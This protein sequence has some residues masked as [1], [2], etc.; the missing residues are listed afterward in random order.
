MGSLSESNVISIKIL[1][2]WNRKD[3]FMKNRIIQRT[4][5]LIILLSA[6]RCLLAGCGKPT[7]FEGYRVS[8]EKGFWMEYAILDREETV[9]MSLVEGE[10]L[11]VSMTH[12]IGDVD[13]RVGRMGK[14]PIYQ[15][16]GQTN[17]DFVLIIP[18]TG[19]YR[20]S[21]TGHRAKG[22]VSFVRTA[23]EED[24]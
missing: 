3:R 8:D 19:T 6:V 2:I 4:F 9:D 24:Q 5:A 20:I 10:Q 15:G 17:A 14:E 11:Q 21:I 18:E 22:A 7:A 13:V 12:V 1:M 16:S 23:A